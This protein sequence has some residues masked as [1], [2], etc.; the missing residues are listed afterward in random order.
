M[1]YAA[2]FFDAGETLVHPHPTFPDLFAAILRREGHDVD[3]ETVRSRVHV[4][5]DRFKRAADDNEL[6]TTT[7]ERSRRFWHDVYG[8]F[9]R[10]LDIGEPDGLVDRLYTEFTDLANYRLFEDVPPVLDRLHEAGILLGVVS[11][12]EEWLEQLLEELGVLGRFDVRVISGVE[13]MEK[14]DPRIF[15]LAL[16]RAGVEPADAVYVGDDP[17]M[18]IVPATAVGM[19]PVLIDRRGRFPEAQ[20]LRLTSMSD[21]PGVLGL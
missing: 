20:G 18:D 16:D 3:A 17:V 14:P 5:F 21:L 8:I 12:F 10:D 19:L 9:L 1:R 4:V 2:V 13:G 15:R 7:P 6:W 11:N